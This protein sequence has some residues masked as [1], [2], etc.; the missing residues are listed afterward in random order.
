MIEDDETIKGFFI[1]IKTVGIED[2]GS[3]GPRLLADLRKTIDEFGI[4][5]TYL[6]S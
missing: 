5:D 4:A 1:K 2:P 3:N 6:V